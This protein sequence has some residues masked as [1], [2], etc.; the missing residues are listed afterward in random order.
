MERF[1]DLGAKCTGMTTV[2]QLT[3][4]SLHLRTEAGLVC[5]AGLMQVGVKHDCET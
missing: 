3:R 5:V 4:I 1:I 2:L